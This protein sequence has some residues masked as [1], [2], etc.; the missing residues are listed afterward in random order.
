MRGRVTKSCFIDRLGH[1]LGLT[2]CE[3]GALARLETHERVYR[4]GAMI[5]REHERGQD[6]AI[7]QDGW[8][9]SFLLFDDGNRQILRLHLPGELV[10][11]SSIAFGV[12][13][14]SLCALTDAR[15]CLLDRAE[16]A[17]L[18]VDHPRLAALLFGL[19]QV[20]QV[21]MGDR[22]AAIG[23]MSAKARVAALILDTMARLR[24]IRADTGQSFIFPL[25]QEEIGDAI[26]L[27]AVH[28]NRMFR[29]LVEGGLIARSGNRLTVLDEP[30][31][32][33]V[34]HFVDRYTK[35][36]TAWMPPAPE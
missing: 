8:L 30:Q 13:P 12:A 19:A 23:R 21:A 33:E 9:A 27:T 6:F 24:L 5:R 15:L 16:L 28:V 11:L 34:A 20:E 17:R 18:F 26:G 31:L 35:L 3:R 36:E 1:Y 22:L 4:R 7:L 25:T 10:G 29:I 2:P 32:V 14:E